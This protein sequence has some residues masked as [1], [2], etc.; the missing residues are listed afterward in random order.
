VPGDVANQR[1]LGHPEIEVLAGE[2]RGEFR[3]WLRETVG[4]FEKHL[5]DRAVLEA[6]AA[7]QRRGGLLATTNYDFLLEHVTGLPTAT[8]RAPAD[9][10]RALRGDEPQVLHLHGA[11][12]W[13]D[14][15][16]LG[17][18]SY[19]DV[20]RDPHA[21]AVLTTL[22]TGRTFV[23]VGCGAGLRD[24]NLGTF[25]RWTASAYAG[26]EYRHFRLCRDGELAALKREHPDALMRANIDQLAAAVNRRL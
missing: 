10:E 4:E 22:R 6:L 19:D 7:H 9:V 5:A 11:W 20:A 12:R 8:W 26:S 16:V 14:S 3:R 21:R 18:R 2:E 15:V 24:P 25:L 13:T 1:D 23:F 17:I